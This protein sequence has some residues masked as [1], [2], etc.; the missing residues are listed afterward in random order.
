MISLTDLFSPLTDAQALE[1]TLAVARAVGLDVD[2]WSPG[3]PSRT[4]LTIASRGLAWATRAMAKFHAGGFR[5]FAKGDQMSLVAEDVYG[6]PRSGKT[7]ATGVVTLTNSGGG[8]YV[9]ADG[10]LTLSNSTTGKTY[11]NTSGGTLGS[12]GTLDVDVIAEEAGS[13]GTSAIGDLDTLVTTLLGV[14][15]ANA[16]AVVGLDEETDD[17]LAALCLESL[18][19]LSPMGAGDVYS[20][21]AKRTKRIDGSLIEI[22]RV[23]VITT[24]LTGDITLVLATP[25]GAPA[26]ADVTTIDDKCQRTAVPCTATLTTQAVTEAALSITY[27]A[28][29]PADCAETDDELKAAIE[30]SLVS[31]A[32]AFPIGGVRKVPGAGYVFHDLLAA[33]ISAAS[34]AIFS[35]T[36]SAPAA[37]VALL[38]TDVPVVTIVSATIVRV[39]Q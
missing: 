29:V 30:A 27:T 8:I 17:E 5:S 25:S 6:V 2:S 22:N 19:A 15:C 20:Y 34:P 21:V 26:G 9:I 32:E 1:T 28:Y 36:L 13:A 14:T 35:K 3:D 24:S 11:R 23:R 39:Q 38:E 7:Y 33:R 16:A 12:G 31:Y 37:D 18:A 4:I 10:D